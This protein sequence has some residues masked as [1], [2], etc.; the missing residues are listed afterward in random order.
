MEEKDLTQ[1]ERKAYELGYSRGYLEAIALA[2][3]LQDKLGAQLE[4]LLRLIQE[5]FGTKCEPS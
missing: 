3:S 1:L 4:E 2:T 5:K